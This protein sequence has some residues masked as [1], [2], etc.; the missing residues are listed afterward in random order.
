M[1]DVGSNPTCAAFCVTWNV[2]S[3]ATCG[4]RAV[5]RLVGLDGVTRDGVRSFSGRP[6]SVGGRTRDEQV[7]GEHAS[8]RFPVSELIVTIWRKARAILWFPLT[9]ACA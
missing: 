5:L 7:T 1:F 9:P 6:A 8:L 2:L 4:A 3:C